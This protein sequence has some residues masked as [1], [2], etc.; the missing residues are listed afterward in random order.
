MFLFH[1]LLEAV[2]GEGFYSTPGK[3]SGQLLPTS[4]K[5]QK[6]SDEVQTFTVRVEIFCIQPQTFTVTLQH[7][8]DKVQTFTA[9]MRNWS[10]MAQLFIATP[11]LF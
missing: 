3:D 2:K 10:F 4:T 1:S 8:C 5:E 9:T 7:F 11:Q 6:V